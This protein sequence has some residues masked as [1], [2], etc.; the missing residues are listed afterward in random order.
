MEEAADAAQHSTAPWPPAS[1]ANARLDQQ[2]GFAM[3]VEVALTTPT[4]RQQRRWPG[5]VARL[6]QGGDGK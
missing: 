4:R 1:S 6:A 5:A 2:I 3:R